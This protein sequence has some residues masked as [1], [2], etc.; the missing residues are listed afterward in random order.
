M[1]TETISIHI[2][3]LFKRP[4]QHKIYKAYKLQNGKSFDCKTKEYIKKSEETVFEAQK[5]RQFVVYHF[6]L[7]YL[8]DGFGCHIL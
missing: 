6:F 1:G 4:T 7:V 5:S 2:E 3:C 8:F